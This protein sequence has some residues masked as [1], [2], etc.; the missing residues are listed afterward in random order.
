[1]I[2]RKQLFTAYQVIVVISCLFLALPAFGQQT[3]SEVKAMPFGAVVTTT[4]TISCDDEFGI[5]RYMQDADAGIA[6]YDDDLAFTSAGDSVVVTGVLSRYRGQVQISPVFSFDILSTGKNTEPILLDDLSKVKNSTYE[7]RRVIF[8]CSGIA[9]C[10]SQLEEG[11]Y[12][13]FDPY[14]NISRLRVSEDLED[15]DIA[16]QSRPYTMEGIWTKFE[17]QYELLALAVADAS[18]GNCHYI[19]PPTISFTG[20]AVVLAWHDL[21]LAETQVRIGEAT[22]DMVFD[23]GSWQ[24]TLHFT[25]D[26]LESGKLYQSVLQQEGQEGKLFKSIPVWFAKPSTSNSIEILFN[27]NVNQSF[28]DGSTPFATGSSAILTDLIARIDQV[29]STLEVAMYNT[30]NNSVVQ[31]VNR[32]ANRGVEVRYIADD[33]TSN[34]ALDGVQ[35]FPI[36]YRQ[37]DGI[38][39]NKFFVA[40]AEDPDHA[41]LWAGSTN[42]S[43]NQ[44]STDPNHAYVI[45]DQA[46]ALSYRREFDEMWGSLPDQSAVRSGDEKTDNTVH[47]FLHNQILYESYFSPSD[48]TACY[49][50]DALRTTDYHVEIGLLLLTHFELID[51]IIRLHQSGMAVRVIVDDEDSSDTALSRLRQAGVPVAVHDPNPIFHHKY[52]IIDEGY[53]D[54]DPQVVTG[55]HNWTWSADNIND[56]NTLIIHDQS[57]ANIFRQEFE[58]RWEELVPT[59]VSTP[60]RDRFVMM[61]NPASDY[62]ILNFDEPVSGVL[63]VINLQGQ[64]LESHLLSGEKVKKVDFESTLAPGLYL[65]RLQST[66]SN[67]VASLIVQ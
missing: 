44:L 50:L 28:S 2:N 31:A 59:S 49:I 40:D 52:A 38:M 24:N 32:A 58:A 26:N 48:E 61:P 55:S 9:S 14:G 34:S 33:Q 62:T 41:W 20:D 37:G 7:S 17:D 36:L 5:I 4:G 45:Y 25:A 10:E 22:P 56:E 15:E 64:I 46:L 11:V 53:P 42:L 47:S 29:R 16:I 63:S 67:M 1:M 57:V 13:M 21:L 30:N 54:S 66:E 51:E 12:R 8:S 27:R 60:S 18:E 3:I 35:S 23:I 43:T 39:H 65:I 6:I 19:S